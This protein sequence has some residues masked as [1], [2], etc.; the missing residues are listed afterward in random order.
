MS[1]TRAN[2]SARTRRAGGAEIDPRQQ[3]TQQRP[4][5][6]QQQQQ[7]QLQSSPKL[8]IPDVFGL[9]SLRLGKLEQ[10]MQ[11]LQTN[12]QDPT[13][14]PDDNMRLIDAQ[15]FES[16]V[17]RLDIM[18]HKQKVLESKPNHVLSKS[19]LLKVDQ[20][21]TA[22][23]SNTSN[24]ANLLQ[25]YV[26]QDKL[27]KELASFST[28]KEDISDI[29]NMMLKLQSFTME[30]NNKLCNVIF[31]DTPQFNL[32]DE[33]EELIGEEYIDSNTLSFLSST[34]INI[35]DLVQLELSKD[36]NECELIV[37]EHLCDF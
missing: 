35:K 19:D 21:I 23:S 2:A 13:S 28:L 16:I 8:S 1:G 34:G 31:S 7:Q 30:T 9:I 22:T 3:Q 14:I 10:H 25:G 5:Q 20:N 36:N 12:P 4:M 18:E 17:K 26:T 27:T 37:E 32:E 6:Q 29:K 24:V 15:V 11:Y 33:E